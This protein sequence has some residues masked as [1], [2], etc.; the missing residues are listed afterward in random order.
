[1]EQS[2]QAD[3]RKPMS[4][5]HWVDIDKLKANNYNPNRFLQSNLDLLKRS[6]LVN[7]LTQPIVVRKDYTIIDGFHRYTVCKQEPLF[8]KLSGKIAV[9]FVEHDDSANDRYATITHNRARGSHTLEPMKAII[10]GLLVSGKTV[11]EISI[12]LGM[13]SEEIFRLSDFSRSQFLELMVRNAKNYSPA[14]VIIKV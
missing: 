3:L 7:G 11:D 14:K 2:G 5:L 10:K 1:L 8:G 6:I 4:T 13:R 9:V 12:E